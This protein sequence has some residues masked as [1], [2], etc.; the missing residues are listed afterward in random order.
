[1]IST[2][3]CEVSHID[4]L[5]LSIKIFHFFFQVGGKV[6][7]NALTVLCRLLCHRMIW[8]RKTVALR[9]TEAVMMYADVCGLS[10]E[11]EEQAMKILTEFDWENTPIEEIRKQRN[12]LCVLFDV[13]IPKLV[14]AKET[15]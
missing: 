6:T 11:A 13:P 4:I 9:L 15:T 1:M 5:L 3:R 12:E 10:E 2:T 7:K 14:T 8:F